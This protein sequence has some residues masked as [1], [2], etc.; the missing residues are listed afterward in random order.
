MLIGIPAFDAAM[1]VAPF[2]FGDPH[3]RFGA[4]GLLSNAMMIP[5]AGVLI[6]LTAATAFDH[7]RTLRTTGLLSWIVAVLAVLM[8]GLFALDA[9]QTR[10][11]ARPGLWL[12]FRVAAITAAGKMIIGA[13][14]FSA[15]G[16]AGWRGGKPSR[17]SKT[18][19]GGILVSSGGS[20]GASSGASGGSAREA[21][22]TPSK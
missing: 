9:V 2:R 3:W 19:G 5:A 8:L 7:R 16:M 13:I 11:D 4:A 6:L 12:S 22:K 18:R 15:F 10:A 17:S 14:A 21:N 1:S 20:S